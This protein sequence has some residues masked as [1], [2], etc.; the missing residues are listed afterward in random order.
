[1]ETRSGGGSFRLG[2]RSAD[3]AYYPGVCAVLGGHCEGSE[4]PVGAL[5]RELAE[6]MGVVRLPLDDV[7]V[8]GEPKPAVNGEARCHVFTVTA[9]ADEPRLLGSEHAEMRRVTLGKAMALPPAHPG[10]GDLFSKVLH[11]NAGVPV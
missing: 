10:Y 3:S 5:L 2:K 11:G 7:A 1:V 4:T 8:Q 9:W 6:E